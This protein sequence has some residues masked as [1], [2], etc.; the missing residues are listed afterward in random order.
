M[1]QKYN[2]YINQKA[3]I[4]TSDAPK[5]MLDYQLIEAQVFD[6]LNFYQTLGKN[7]KS[8]FYIISKKPKDVFNSIKSKLK[9]IEA[10]GG[11]VINEDEKYLFI[12]R[13]GKW[14]LPKGKLEVNEKKKDAAVREVEEECGIK[15]KKLDKK[16]LKTYHI[17]ELK[18][19]VV[20]KISHW[21]AMHAK[22]NQKLKPQIEEGITEV[23]WFAKQDWRIVRANTYP[24]IIDVINQD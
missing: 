18:G 23:K 22:G 17:Y 13:N 3:L 14:D 21:Y 4:V 5:G 11:L 10:A 1:A 6:F 7:P 16:L 2:I 15:V 24:N 8:L 9:V 19:R 12:K 20:L